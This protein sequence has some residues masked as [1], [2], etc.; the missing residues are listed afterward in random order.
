MPAIE[1]AKFSDRSTGQGRFASDE[2]YS[3]STVM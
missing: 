2:E 3:V 1:R